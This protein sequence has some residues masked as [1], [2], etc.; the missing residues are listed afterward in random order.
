MPNITQLMVL[1]LNKQMNVITPTN[2]NE[3]AMDIKWQKSMK[4]PKRSSHNNWVVTGTVTG[5]QLVQQ[6]GS[7][8]YSSCEAAGKAAGWWL[9][10]QLGNS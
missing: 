9:V 5:Q 8:C 4:K 7:G 6:L 1:D 10:Q 2:Y 3:L